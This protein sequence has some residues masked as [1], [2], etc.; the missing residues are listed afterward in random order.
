MNR[1]YKYNTKFSLRRK[2]IY[3]HLTV[4]LFCFIVLLVAL[5]LNI[6]LGE[7]SKTLATIANPTQ[8]IDLQK[9]DKSVKRSSA[10]LV[11]NVA[12]ANIGVN[13]WESVWANEIWSLS[14]SLAPENSA[15]D[16][17]DR[18][19][20]RK[21]R[22]KL[23]TLQTHQWYIMDIVGKQGNLPAEAVLENGASTVENGIN[24]G[25]ADLLNMETERTDNQPNITNI[26]IVA[27]LRT[28]FV[29]LSNAITRFSNS[30]EPLDETE[31]GEL[32][33]EIV[34][35]MEILNREHSLSPAQRKLM[36]WLSGEFRFY[37]DA[38]ERSITIRKSS[39][40]NVARYMLANKVMPLTKEIDGLL[41]QLLLNA[42]T[43]IKLR[44]SE[45]S[46]LV[47]SNLMLSG[48]LLSIMLLSA[49]FSAKYLS[50]K[51]VSPIEQL[52]GATLKLGEEQKAVTIPESGNDELGLL[53]SAFNKMQNI[54]IRKQEELQRL[55][56]IDPLT[57]LA[58]RHMFSGAIEKD[59]KR[60]L[61]DKSD[62]S[63]I[64]IDVDYFKLFNDQYGHQAGD[65]ALLEVADVIRECLQRS[66]D[67]AARYGGEEFLIVLPNTNI[68]G[69]NNVA[70]KIAKTLGERKIPAA[71][72]A[73]YPFLSVSCG[74]SVCRPTSQTGWEELIKAA[75]AAL[76]SAKSN[77]RNQVCE[78]TCH[79]LS[80]QEVR[81][82][83]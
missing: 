53:A 54:L 51:I 35:L 11:E 2:L 77:G 8:Q 14:S 42:A 40:W 23:V 70:L 63:I 66:S 69:A 20:L 76:Y 13:E 71:D 28:A 3:S 41:E 47:E 74:V 12:L 68:A 6:W 44:S 29:S 37:F 79:I 73:T 32:H 7:R 17:K 38:V 60:C 55:A 67:L 16:K 18:R 49:F 19:L 31:I 62:I 39:R 24:R 30:G 75:D 45:L 25:L 78:S 56:T 61:R 36:N 9:V 82:P 83:I 64:M 57:K 34:W 1:N 81:M 72:G 15:Y 43:K 59:W 48:F 50:Y 33:K 58:N 52:V 26:K 65:N 27:D 4:A 5:F 10:L 80:S 22:Q 21:L 46:S